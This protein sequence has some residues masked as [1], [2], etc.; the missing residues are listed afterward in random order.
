MAGTV[1]WKEGH[2][3]SADARLVVALVDASAGSDVGHVLASMQVKAPGAK[4]IPFQVNYKMSD[5]VEGASYRVVAALLDG[6]LAWLNETGVEVAVPEPVITDVSVPLTYRPDL[7]KAEITGSI[8]GAGLDGSGSANS[9]AS[10]VVV[11]PGTGQIIGFTAIAPVGAAPIPFSVAYSL[12]DV[13]PGADYIANATAWDGTV[14]WTGAGLTRVIT[15]GN[16]TTGITIPV[17][18]GPAPTAAPTSAPISPDP[19]LPVVPDYTSSGI[20]FGGFVLLLGAVTLAAF[21]LTWAWLGIRR[22]RRRR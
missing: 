5:V 13:E 14:F 9:Y 7:L 18:A 19:T 21:L 3:P 11:N 16:P 22:G 1:T 15:K 6:E 12:T 2:V 8:A 4:P 10:V 20:G 17:S